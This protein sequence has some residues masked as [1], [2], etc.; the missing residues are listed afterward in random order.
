MTIWISRK[1]PLFICEHLDISWASHIHPSQN[2]WPFQFAE[3]F[4]VQFRLSR[5][6][7]RLNQH[8][9][10]M[11]WPFEFP[12]SFR[13]SF[14]RV[15]IYHGPQTYKRVKSYGRLHM[16]R[17]YM[18][19]FERL[20]ISCAEIGD[21]VKFY[22]QFR[23][24]W[25][26]MSLNRTSKWKVMT[27]WISWEISLFIF[28]HLDITWASHIHQSQKLW[29][30]EFTESIRVQFRPSRYIVRMNQHPSEMVWPF[31]FH[32]GFR[33]SFFSVLI[34]DGPY[35]YTRVKCYGC[36]EFSESF[37]VQFQESR[38]IMSLNRTS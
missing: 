2:L 11:L 9:S 19:N 4:R 18:F 38:Y 17:P 16:S 1:P 33:C 22:V 35:T 14:S 29:P 26:I 27:I 36:F 21:R 15:S 23:E 6:Y 24:C 3:S 20:D 34:Y 13:C 28:E 37:C 12:E 31:K 10:E 25:Y 7:M 5:Y 32:K 30:F 8:P